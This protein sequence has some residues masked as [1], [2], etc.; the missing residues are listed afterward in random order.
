MLPFLLLLLPVDFA[1]PFPD[2]NHGYVAGPLD[3][4]SPCPGLN[5][6]ANH[7]FLNRNGKDIAFQEAEDAIHE[8]FGLD[9]NLMTI[10]N[11][12]SNIRRQVNDTYV[13]S[14]Y[15]LWSR[16][17]VLI[18]KDASLLY[19]DR[20]LDPNHTLSDALLDGLQDSAG[21]DG[22]LTWEELADWRDVRLKDSIERNPEFSFTNTESLF[23]GEVA[24]SMLM[25]AAFG[26]DPIL[27][28]ARI[29]DV[30][31]FM[32]D[33]KLPQDFVPRLQRGESSRNALH[34]PLL[35]SMIDFFRSRFFRMVPLK[36]IDNL[37]ETP[38][39]ADCVGKFSSLQFDLL[40]YDQYDMYFRDDSKLT[41][42]Q[43]GV[44]SGAKDIEEY[45]RFSGES[46]PYIDDDQT[47]ARHTL[48]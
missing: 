47:V 40:N 18:D 33:N 11:P 26:D 7:G 24:N 23:F 43:A 9:M 34:D 35:S 14:L 32:R 13:F 41:L 21:P 46:S 39:L 29:D 2:A 5:T 37:E 22:I 10:F 42:A 15:D 27:A 19:Q 38:T 17:P 4:R 1:T 30:M 31:S 44:Y 16:D 3:Q 20:Y 45:V 12:F 28:T 8:V 36:A 48:F 25:F 6:L